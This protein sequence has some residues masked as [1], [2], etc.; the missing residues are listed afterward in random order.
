MTT[1]DGSSVAA[2]GYRPFT[3]KTFGSDIDT[4][5]LQPGWSIKNDGFG[6]LESSVVFRGDQNSA[7]SVPLKGEKHIRDERLFCYRVETTKVQGGFLEAKADYCGIEDGNMT[8]IKLSISASSSTDPIE[9]HPNF[10]KKIGG[11]PSKPLNGAIF[12]DP[13]TNSP[14]SDDGKG[15]FSEFSTYADFEYPPS[16]GLGKMKEKNRFA[17]VKNF[18]NP[19]VAMKGEFFTKD[20]ATADKVIGSVGK[21]SASG[22]FGGIDLI[23]AWAKAAVVSALKPYTVEL[24]GGKLLQRNFLLS[25]ASVEAYGVVYKI[26]Y[27]LVMGGAL[28]WIEEIYPDAVKSS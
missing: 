11:K 5:F 22:N 24:V 8:E 19:G 15:I 13:A 14:T 16:S 21:S 4:Y 28:G 10:E 18:Y 3:G 6:L 17:G 25:S 27:D 23:P 12:I 26:N 20:L 2:G 9:T 7:G 1:S